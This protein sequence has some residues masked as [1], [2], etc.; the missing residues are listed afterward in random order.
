PERAELTI[1]D[2]GGSRSLHARPPAMA[3]ATPA[4][5]EG[6]G[7]YVPSR[8]AAGTQS[9]F[10][11]PD[12][13]R[14][15]AGGA[16]P[17]AGRGVLPGGFSMPGTVQAFE[18]RGAMAQIYIHPGERIH[19]GICTPIWGAPTLESLA[20]KPSTPVV[21]INKPDGQAL[22]AAIANQPVRAAVRAWLREG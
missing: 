14:G 20:A 1:T 16:D 12:A 9:L 7:C 15:G 6:E 10:D 8:Y 3:R 17:V 22:I 5:G 4:P 13:A 18:R 11:T 2:R 19:E 21:C